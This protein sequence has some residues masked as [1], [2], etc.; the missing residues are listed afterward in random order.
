MHKTLATTLYASRNCYLCNFSCN[1]LKGLNQG[2]KIALNRRVF[3]TYYDNRLPLHARQFD[4]L[5][6]ISNGASIARIRM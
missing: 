6:A 2:S 1:Y 4:Q 3:I 5:E